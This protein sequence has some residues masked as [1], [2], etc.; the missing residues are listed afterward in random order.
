MKNIIFLRFRKQYNN[1]FKPP[2]GLR[3]PGNRFSGFCYVIHCLKLF[4]MKSG[5]S[6]ITSFTKKTLYSPLYEFRA[7]N[8]K[9]HSF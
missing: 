9:C 6:K 3:D 4:L 5:I 1:H 8:D 2:N 7:K